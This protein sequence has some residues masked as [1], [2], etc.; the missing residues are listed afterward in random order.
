MSKRNGRK[1]IDDY[2]SSLNNIKASNKNKYT[3]NSIIYPKDPKNIVKNSLNNQIS[4]INM[5][6]NIINKYQ[7][8]L[9]P[10]ALIKDQ[11]LNDNFKNNKYCNYTKIRKK[12][13]NKNTAKNLRAKST[14]KEIK[15]KKKFYDYAD[16]INDSFMK[17][18]SRKNNS[19][20]RNRKDSK[21]SSNHKMISYNPSFFIKTPKKSDSSKSYKS[22]KSYKSNKSN[23]SSK[24]SKRLKSNKSIEKSKINSKGIVNDYS[25]I[26]YK[27]KKNNYNIKRA[28][29]NTDIKKE[30]KNRIH[31]QKS[32]KKKK[33]IDLKNKDN[34]N[35]NNHLYK[36]TSYDSQKNLNKK[37]KRDKRNSI[38]HI[39]NNKEI[40]NYITKRNIYID[41]NADNFSIN[42]K[43]FST[44][45]NT[46]LNTKCNSNNT[47]L[48]TKCNSNNNTNNNTLKKNNLIKV[49]NS[50]IINNNN[51]KNENKKYLFRTSPKENENK[52]E[53]SFFGQK[54]INLNLQETFKKIKNE[55]LNLEIYDSNKK[56]NENT[57]KI[58]NSK[59]KDNFEN[60][61]SLIANKKAKN[62][63]Q[64]NS[65]IKDNKKENLENIEDN[66]EQFM[67]ENEQGMN[68]GIN[69]VK[70]NNFIINKPKEENLKY[71]SIKEFLDDNEDQTEVSPSQI[72]KIIIGQ[73]DGYK[74]IIDDDKNININDK[75]KS[76]LEL[77][78]KFS[79]SY[80][81]NNKQSIENLDNLYLF[82][83]SNR[84]INDRYINITN[85]SRNMT[86]DNNMPNLTNIKNVDEEYDSE[87]LSL[88][89]F[90]N[91]IKSINA[92]SNGFI[93]K[94]LYNK[95]SGKNDSKKKDFQNKNVIK[96]SMNT[97]NTTISSGN[98]IN[99]DINNNIMINI[100]IN[101]E[102]TKKNFKNNKISKFN[103]SKNNYKNKKSPPS[104][105]RYNLTNFKISK[106]SKSN[107]NSK[108]I[109]NKNI[110]NINNNNRNIIY[111]NNIKNK[112]IK[113][114]ESI[115]KQNAIKS[116]TNTNIN[117]NIDTNI[118]F[119]NKKIKRIKMIKNNDNLLDK[120]QLN[121]EN[122]NVPKIEEDNNRTKKISNYNIPVLK[123]IGENDK[124]I[125]A[126][127]NDAEN[128]KKIR[129]E[130]FFNKSDNTDTNAKNNNIQCSI[131]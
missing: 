100:K 15:S 20:L 108:K 75:S 88:S 107:S 74:D 32:I 69:S 10:R 78:S 85:N 24:S 19:N 125:N 58:I 47:N 11:Y 22:Y 81:K 30:N 46:N 102:I 129:N 55:N 116:N 23:K 44:Q 33:T 80:I 77:L 120:E 112:I 17:Y 21:K 93:N 126:Y 25:L 49:K 48:N 95:S 119:K 13:I 41:L 67:T 105:T 45:N 66:G 39:K 98:N 90:K 121:D 53:K 68:I 87:D 2:F 38:S 104:S 59:N 72:S 97:N 4:A 50:L 128:D 101:K 26:I 89:V 122:G 124:I 106:N 62:Y 35:I 42:K 118:I 29:S 70:T 61:K 5:E 65:N 37:T 114:I 16:K 52:E 82:E 14:K 28:S 84:E 94:V 117:K 113:N 73:I 131:F 51:S 27:N 56:I 7:K 76:L 40:D 1:Y 57:L 64:K 99:K 86:S 123:I 96:N 43:F 115:K 79:F 60:Q 63:F 3:S 31:K 12:S 111:L 92:H 91:N 6:F 34:I 83:E 71:S 36:V 54:K 8:Y 127:F 130:N 18:K 9:S 109:N 110:V 103:N